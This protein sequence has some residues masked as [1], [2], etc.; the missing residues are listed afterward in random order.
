MQKM[1]EKSYSADQIGLVVSSFGSS[2]AVET[3]TGQIISCPLR[4]NQDTPVVGDQVYWQIENETGVIASIV[5][6]RSLLI[7]GD[8]RGKQKQKPIAANID[9]I[10]I[11]AAPPP[12]FSEYLLDRYL[13]AAELLTIPAIIVFNKMYLLTHPEMISER[14]APYRQIPYPIV[15]TSAITLY[16]LDELAI[17]LKNKQAVLVGPSGVGKSSIIAALCEDKPP[18]RIGEVSPKGIGK[19]TTTTM[20]LYHLP[21]GGA[22][23]DSP[24]V[25]EFHLW[26]VRRQEIVQGFKEFH[27]YFN[28]CK[29]RDCQHLAEPN[30]AVKS[31]VAD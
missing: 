9:A 26:P 14:L 2:V 1:N 7:R 10:V 30:C 6:R 15:Q 18:I 3:Q 23:I 29:F 21:F 4:R 16:G 22:I 25:R 17:H 13:I 27:Q 20:Q 24:G 8:H 19:H 31:A 28:M 12:V 5:P 11:V